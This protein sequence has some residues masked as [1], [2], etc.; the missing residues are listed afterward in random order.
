MKNVSFPIGDKKYA[1]LFEKQIEICKIK[2][3]KIEFEYEIQY[4]FNSCDDLNVVIDFVN[5][6]CK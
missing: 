6:K 1:T 2:Y 3:T 4:D 5:S